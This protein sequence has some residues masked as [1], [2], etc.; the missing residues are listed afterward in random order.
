MATNTTATTQNH[1]GTGS[2]NNF[3]ISFAFL[4]NTEVDV[5]VG[6][7]LKT[8][9][10]H[11][12]IVGS[13]VQFTSGNTPPSGTANIVLT[14]NTDISAKKVDFADGSV[15]TET[16]LDNNSDQIL[17][18]QQEFTNDFVKRDGSQ[19]VTGNLVFEGVTDDGNETTLAI[20]DPTADRTITVP[21][22]TGTLV[23]TGDTGTVSNQMIANDAVTNA[24]IADDSIDSEHYVDGSIDTQHIANENITTVKLA[25][26]AVT[27]AKL[28][29][30]AVV[31]ANITDSNVTTAKIASNAVTNVEIA[32]GTILTGNIANGNITTDK[33]ADS[34]VT[35]AKL[36]NLNV[37][38][39][40]LASNAVTN[41]KIADNSID[42]EHY[43]DGSIDTVHIADSQITTNKLANQ[44]VTAAK[45]DTGTII[46]NNIADGAVTAAKIDTGTIT[47]VK[48]ANGAI[49]NSKLADDAVTSAKL[50]D[51]S[52]ANNHLQPQ[53]VTNDKIASA[54]ILSGNIAA[55]NILES[56]LADNAV[57]TAKIANDA[58]NSNKIAD[59][60]VNFEHIVADAVRTA[61]IQDN[62]V[63][64]D[65]IA[66][67]AIVT[68]SE[69]ASHSVNDTTFFT[70]AAAEARYFNAS[71][72][73]TIKNGD[74][75]PDNDTTIAT[76]A[77]INDR[78]IDLVD[79]V[80]GF[81]PIANETSFP[82]SNPDVNN[83]SGTIVSVKAASTNLTPSG[84]T[85]TIANGRGSGLAVIITGVT[86]TIPSGFGFLVETT[87]TDHTYAFHR[88]VPK[89]TEVT[90]VAG[91]AVE[92]G[93]LGTADAV[94]DMA[95]LGTTDV[96]AD[97]N[98]LATSDVVADMALLATTDVIADMA[99]L[100]VA[101]VISDMND[102]ATSSNITAMSTCSTNIASINNA[103]AN[104]A[105]ANNFGD[106]YQVAANNPT[107]DGGGNALA[108]G[109]LYFN[110]SANELK[111]YTGSAWQGGVTATG[112]FAVVTGN[113]FTGDN[114]YNDNVKA[115][116]GTGSDFQI[117]HDAT[118]NI[119]QA[120]GSPKLRLRHSAT[121]GSNVKNAIVTIADGEVELYHNNNKKLHTTS[122]GIYVTGNIELP[123]DGE[124]KLGNSGDLAIYHNDSL[125]SSW[126]YN[127]TGPLQIRSDSI[128]LRSQ[129]D[130]ASYINCT[131]N[132]AV[133]LYFDGTKMLSTESRGAILQ[134]ADACTFIVGSTNG[135]SAQ[136]FLDGDSNGDGNGGDYAAIRHT[137]SG[138]FEIVADNPSTGAEIHF[139]TGNG[140]HRSTIDASGHFKPAA[141]STYD[142]GLTGTRWRNLYADTL[143]GDGSNLT[144][145]NT[146]LVGDTSPQLGGN[147]DLNGNSI[148]LDDNEK[149]FIGTGNDGS[150]F[151]TGSFLFLKNHS[152]AVAIQGTTTLSLQKYDNADIGLQYVVDGEVKLYYDNS[153]KFETTSA[154]AQVTGTLNHLA[155]S[156]TNGSGGSVKV[157]NNSGKFTAGGSDDLQMYHDGSNSYI[158]HDGTGDF[159]I[160]TTQNNENLL[161]AGGQGVYLYANGSENAVSCVQNGAVSL[162]YDNAK[163]FETTSGG[164]NLPSGNFTIPDSGGTG[165]GR[166]IIGSGEDLKIY[167]DGTKSVINEGG[168]GWLEINTNN[169]R[170]QNAAANETL[171]YATENGS[172]QLMYDNAKKLET[173]SDGVSITGSCTLSSNLVLGDGD[174]LKLGASSD[175]TI[176][177]SGSDFN[178]YNNTGQIIISNASG[179]GTGEGAIIFKTGN[180]NT[181][182]YLGNDGHFYPASNNSFDLG[183]NSNRW[184][185]VF[186]NDLNLSNEGGA[187][188]VDGT[189]GSYTIQE[190]AE[191]LFLINKRNGKKYKF[192]LTEVS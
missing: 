60:S 157:T 49:T 63:T 87:S 74:T 55:G 166:L 165:Y 138:H 91:K 143:Y 121:D 72:G 130:A 43:I 170:V 46:T 27:S 116:Y 76:T 37:T 113:T 56:K 52:V 169:L 154:G 5:K 176:W 174:E 128:F 102:L 33:I 131:D 155:G 186:T 124:L 191:S 65:K 150:L 144:G 70:T 134:K 44:A 173:T 57:T 112:N 15:L 67:A 148:L 182:A 141:D 189:W 90:T 95:L 142:L 96:I 177:H 36:A 61:E 20:T 107:T 159:Y 110:T 26:D 68:N 84:T 164:V 178:M 175:M 47:T 29:D 51:T 8:L 14:R 7:V 108:A 127:S 119:I 163:K 145:I 139:K 9:G 132:G 66:D 81:V 32:S 183:T 71:T 168:T 10:T 118:D 40:K 147:L 73:E 18:A 4:A 3:A 156:Y 13:Q 136:I 184:R 181:R 100:A 25:N 111:V 135:G 171:L 83:G 24:K 106:Q 30:N 98:L 187:N 115:L 133:D 92:I 185:N 151:N 6:G 104:I 180:N 38:T 160:Q 97:M 120:L 58:V 53:S 123:D 149:I 35:T 17:F 126:I 39:E 31:T 125:G 48:I 101:D 89:A 190:G 75:F 188:D 77:A 146:D 34:N 161:I 103:S 179:T 117:Y 94:A 129:S 12:N 82:T 93:R 2:Q 88:L 167:H 41:S 19:T 1:N 86:A 122:G 114:R 78:I 99:L 172:V 54:T 79:D 22:I 42:S 64:I 152:G 80:G 137:S 62:A 21:D 109:D 192:N 45:I 69:Q 28:A 153:K 105:S 16:D 162:Y 85:V 59:N 11:Y 50:A 140:S 158:K 23:T